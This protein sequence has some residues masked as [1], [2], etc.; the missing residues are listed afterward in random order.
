MWEVWLHKDWEHS[1]DDFKRLNAPCENETIT[2]KDLASAVK[3]SAAI[4]DGF[5]PF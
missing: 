1:F 5:N 4:V 2:K 3:A